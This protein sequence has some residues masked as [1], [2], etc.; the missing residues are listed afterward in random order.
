MDSDLQIHSERLQRRS[1]LAAWACRAA[2]VLIPALL[3]VSWVIGDALAAML[4]Q[5]GLPPEPRLSLALLVLAALISL[6]PALALARSLFAAAACFE[7]FARADWFGPSQ[8]CALAKA[9]R[10]LALSGVLGL[11]VPT[12]L[13]LLLT[14]GAAPGARVFAISLSS[15]GVTAMLFGALIWALGHLWALAR[16]IAAENERFV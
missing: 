10:W 15:T 11:V 6:L 16:S 9:G 4:A 14:L 8:P 13:G 3:I 2:G 7:G 5:L 1:R 12:F